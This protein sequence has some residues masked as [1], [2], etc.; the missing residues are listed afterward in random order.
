MGRGTKNWVPKNLDDINVTY[1][2]YYSCTVRKNVK[3]GTL[4]LSGPFLSSLIKFSTNSEVN[5]KS[6]KVKL[7]MKGLCL[8]MIIS[9]FDSKLISVYML[10][11]GGGVAI[12]MFWCAFSEKK[13]KKKWLQTD[14][15]WT[16][17]CMYHW[18][19]TTVIVVSL[20]FQHGG[21]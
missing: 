14:L 2:M 17:E 13:K 16:S 8:S 11:G 9:H 3:F 10:G 18:T 4:S 21:W 5:K 12:R 7:L 20:D 1:T 19:F 15:F 6:S